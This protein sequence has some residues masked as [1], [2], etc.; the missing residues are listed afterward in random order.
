MRFTLSLL[1]LAAVALAV[2]SP[3]ANYVLH[4][5]RAAEPS[6]DTWVKSRRLEADRVLPMRFGLSQQNTHRLE[7][8]LMSVSHPESPSF[9]KHFSAAEVTSIFEPSKETIDSVMEWLGGF[10]FAR[11][12]L[13]LTRNKGWLTVNA[14]AS[15]IEELLNT[16]YHIYTH[17]ETGAEQIGAYP[18]LHPFA[19]SAD[20]DP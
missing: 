20:L 1:S 2:P 6:D 10:G 9:G 19:H 18:S 3:R 14:T 5:K 15:E 16:E 17:T 4:E 12:R 13:S 11:E 8:M 7:E